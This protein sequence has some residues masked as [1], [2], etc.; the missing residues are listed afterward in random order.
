MD[1]N[2]KYFIFTIDRGKKSLYKGV[3]MEET[4]KDNDISISENEVYGE[5]LVS[6]MLNYS[7][8]KKTEENAESKTENYDT[9]DKQ[10]EAIKDT[11]SSNKADFSTLKKE[12]KGIWIQRNKISLIV[13]GSL[14]VFICFIF[15]IVPLFKGKKEVKQE[16]EKRGNVYIPLILDEEDSTLDNE[17]EIEVYRNSIPEKKFNEA[18]M[19]QKFP[20]PI[21]HQAP[22]N[23]SSGKQI[24]VPMTNR[25]EQQKQPGHL[26]LENEN[27]I[28]SQN[29]N[30]NAVYSSS[31]KGNSTITGPNTYTPAALSTNISNYMGNMGNNYELQNNQS[32]KVNFLEGK[33]SENSMQWNSDISL[34]KGTVINGVLD[35]GINT[36]L[37]GQVMGHVTKNVYSSKDSSYLLIPQGSRLFGEYNSLISYGQARV[38]VVWSTLIRPDGLEINLGSMNGIDPYGFA[39]YKGRK[40]EHP[41][42]YMKAMGLIAMFSIMDTK[43]TNTINGETNAYAQ[44][45]ISDAYSEGKRLS[46]KIIERAMDIQPTITLQPGTE[47]TL[48]TNLT[49]ELPPMENIPVTEK[50]EN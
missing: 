29:R 44:N 45:A 21:Q 10:S 28:F 50:Y 20:D 48:I 42:E 19:Q 25:N 2:P 43:I 40:T 22:V 17:R 34:W 12:N 16:Q 31:Y 24:E 1:L 14:I 32:N 46:N 35:T 18:E 11:E 9:L 37:P 30:T 13:L 49:I 4:I 36:D 39:G 26:S 27:S 15:F 38:Q 33:V 5:D 6:K 23:V 8:S 3:L 7:E 41:F 47:V